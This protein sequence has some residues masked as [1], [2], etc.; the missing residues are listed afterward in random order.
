MFQTALNAL[1]PNT[2]VLGY[3]LFLAVNATGVWGGV[4]PFLPMKIQTAE[5]MFQ[6]YL[7]QSLMMFAVFFAL[8]RASYGRVR[9]KPSTCVL[10]AAA[11]YFG[12]WA[13]LIASMYLHQNSLVLVVVGGIFLGCEKSMRLLPRITASANS[14]KNTSG[15]R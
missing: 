11:V 13:F 9:L 12:G 4:F 1:K 3:A 6:F 7:A 10:V 2:T 14:G 15:M 8:A 5:V